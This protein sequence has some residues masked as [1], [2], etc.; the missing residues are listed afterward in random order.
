MNE[1]VLISGKALTLKIKILQTLATLETL[2]FSGVVFVV[3][4]AFYLL[5]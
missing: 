1:T 4:Q 3:L 5:L 2:L